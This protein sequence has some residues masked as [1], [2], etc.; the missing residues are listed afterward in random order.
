[1]SKIKLGCETYTWQMPG[2]Q[3]KGKLPHIMEITSRAGFQG[4]EPETSFI[5]ELSD[6]DLMLENLNKYNLE[7]PVLCL[8]EEWKFDRETPEERTRADMWIRFLKYF[9]DTLL[10]LVQIPG[11][12]RSNLTVRQQHLLSCVNTIAERASEK[13]ITCS[14][15]PNSPKGSV[16]R[17]ED[18]YK[19]LLEGL[20]PELIGYTPDVGH[21]ARGGMDPISIIQKYRDRVNCIHYKDMFENGAWAPLGEGVINFKEI[22]RYL[23]N[24]A[25]EGWIIIEDECEQAIENPDGVTIMDGIYIKNELKPILNNQRVVNT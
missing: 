18:D 13:G 9:P 21:I 16:F 19:V 17:T 7:L 3:F 20:N 11:K 8:A 22:T 24:T 14:Y 23:M 25:F 2:E 5:K 4:L 6:P 15:H 12:D 10:L 1:M